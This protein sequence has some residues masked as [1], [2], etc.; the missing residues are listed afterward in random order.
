MIK[1]FNSLNEFFNKEDRDVISGDYVQTYGYSAINDGGSGLYKV[2]SV[3]DTVSNAITFNGLEVTSK[4]CTLELIPENGTVRVEQ[5]GA[6]SDCDFT[7]MTTEEKNEFFGSNKAAIQI[8]VD[9]GARR[10]EFSAGTYHVADD[11]LIDHPVDIVGNGAKLVLETD[12]TSTQLF[13]VEYGITV[14]DNAPAASIRDMKIVGTRTITEVE[15]IDPETD[16]IKTVEKI[17]YYNDGIRLVNVSGFKIFG[18]DFEYGS[19]AIKASTISSG[20]SI[21]NICVENCNAENIVK[22]FSF[23]DTANLKVYNCKAVCLEKSGMGISIG[24]DTLP[25]IIEDMS[26]YN[27]NFAV[28]VGADMSESKAGSVNFKNLLV[29]GSKYAFW[30]NNNTAPVYFANAMVVNVDYALSNNSGKNISIANS[31]ILLKS[32]EISPDDSHVLYFMGDA[33]MKFVHTQFEFP[34]ILQK[35]SHTTYFKKTAEI[36]FIDCTLQK[37]DISGISDEIVSTGFGDL[38]YTDNSMQQVIET[39][40][41]CEFR[42]YIKDYIITTGEGE[43]AVTTYN[44]PIVLS[45]ATDSGSKLIIKNCRFINEDNSD[46]DNSDETENK[47]YIP[48][49]SLDDNAKFD[50]IVVYN[51]FFENY[52]CS[53]EVETE[54]GTEDVY[55]LF[56]KWVNGSIMTRK[57]DVI[58]NNMH[59]IFA[60]CNMRSSK[61]IRNTGTTINEMKTYE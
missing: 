10:V 31:S 17:T 38:G 3:S 29:D 19:G 54:D 46:E 15:E 36:S 45:T 41:A 33:Q 4:G 51:C 60:K 32:P 28:S 58:A 27:G 35:F 39:F 30:F 20:H 24:G 26:I 22:S 16:E 50:N 21:S 53:Y 9:S 52:N 13:R 57:E 23:S 61:P 7:N 25:A 42:S 18:T 6:V 2:K 56:G 1:N 44:F 48:Y 11:I 14:G 47:E 40:D 43:N 8:A 5:F 55:P 34:K 12:S 59:N 49:F 37:T